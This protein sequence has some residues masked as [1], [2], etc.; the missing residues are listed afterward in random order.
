[1]IFI[2]TFVVALFVA[3]VS[4]IKKENRTI[5][6]FFYWFGLTFCIGMC[7]TFTALFFTVAAML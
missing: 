5:G 4:R 2:A 3:F 1:M 7:I 6:R